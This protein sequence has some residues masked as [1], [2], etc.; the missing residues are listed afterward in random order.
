MAAACNGMALHGGIIPSGASFLCFTD[1]CRA[2]AAHRGAYAASGSC[3]CSPTNSIGLGEDGPTHQPVE[4]LAALRAMPNLYSWRPADSV[5][6]V[7]C[8]QAALEMR[9]LA[10][11]HRADAAGAAGGAHDACRGKPLRAGRL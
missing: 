3:M 4:H 9:A 8:W 1:Y 10:F 7:E 11:D 6:T 2:R 5:E